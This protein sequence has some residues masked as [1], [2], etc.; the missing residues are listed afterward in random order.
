LTGEI[1]TGG[2]AYA[3]YFYYDPSGNGTKKTL[4]GV[5]TT[6]VYNEADQSTSETTAGTTTEY[7][8]TGGNRVTA[9]LFLEKGGYER[10]SRLVETGELERTVFPDGSL[11][12]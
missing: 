8:E 10:I 9:P 1:R 12:L 7:A 4:G 11:A 6:Y 2:S 3:Q 5:D